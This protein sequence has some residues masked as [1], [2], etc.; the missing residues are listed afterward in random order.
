M[1]LG[2]LIPDHYG[3]I[4]HR[5]TT[6]PTTRAQVF[7]AITPDQT[8]I[9]VKVYQGEASTASHNTLLGRFSV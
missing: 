7:S 8:A 3:I 9:N 1:V 5:N 2:R 6:L 4:I